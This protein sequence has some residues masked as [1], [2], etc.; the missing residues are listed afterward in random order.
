MYKRHNHKPRSRNPDATKQ[1]KLLIKR[2]CF[3]NS[4]AANPKFIIPSTHQIR[5]KIGTDNLVFNRVK[6]MM[7]TH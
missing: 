2:L 3:I 1:I 7:L 6:V 5:S 4:F